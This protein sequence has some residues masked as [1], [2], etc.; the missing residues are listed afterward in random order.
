MTMLRKTRKSWAIALAGATIVLT[1]VTTGTAD[2]EP[3]SL[4]VKYLCSFPLI[5][6]QPVTV[7][8]KSDLPKSIKVGESSPEVQ[9]ST[10]STV[11]AASTAGLNLVGARTLEGTA[12][13]STDVVAPQGTLPVQVPVSLTKTQIPPAG[14]FSIPAAGS[15]PGLTFTRAG[16][17]KVTVGK[18]TMRLTPRNASGGTT[19]LGTFT[20]KCS[21]RPDDQDNVLATIE[22][23]G[24]ANS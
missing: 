15:A 18:L 10:L 8:I 11:G 23:L 14:E 24:S 21:L 5:G 7:E 20:S 9:I 19:V 22:I 17:A 4:K 2:A 12:T 16:T 6:A 13:A 1:T 3:V